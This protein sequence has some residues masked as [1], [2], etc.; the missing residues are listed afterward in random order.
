M[1]SCSRRRQNI[2][3]SKVIN[4][5]SLHCACK[6]PER[7]A[8]LLSMPH[9]KAQGCPAA[10]ITGSRDRWGWIPQN[11]WLHPP[12]LPLSIRGTSITFHLFFFLFSGMGP[13]VSAPTFVSGLGKL[14]A[15][16]AAAK[17]WGRS[18]VLSAHTTLLAP[19]KWR[20]SFSHFLLRW[21]TLSVMKW[22]ILVERICNFKNS[23]SFMVCLCSRLG[24]H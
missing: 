20:Y 4:E 1:W 6:I 9:R 14:S 13:R 22:D 7:P 23:A 10:A 12:P 5:P 15:A 8:L 3:G 19:V 18:D 2:L 17:P 16:Q 11:Q 21:N 24:M